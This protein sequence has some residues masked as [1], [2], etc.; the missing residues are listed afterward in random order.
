MKQ[1]WNDIKDGLRKQ[2]PSHSFKM[3]IDPLSFVAEEG[4]AMVLSAPNFFSRKRVEDYYAGAIEEELKKSGEG[5]TRLKVVLS[6]KKRETPGKERPAISNQLILPMMHMQPQNGRRLRREF[7]FDSFVVGG[8]NDFAYSAALSYASGKA[9][10]Q[11]SLFLL[12]NTGMGK[13]HLSQAVGHH[14]LSQSKGDRVY[15]ITAEDFTNEMVQAFKHNCI[16][17][18]KQKYRDGCDV[19]LLE[20]IHFLTG[21]DRTQA[22]LALTLDYL[23]DSRKR[24]I[25]SSCLPPN[26]IPKLSD[27]LRSRISSGLISPI[28]APDFRTR[29]RIVDRKAKEKGIELS[30]EV[31][32]YLASEL[33]EDVRQLESGLIGVAAKSSLMGAEIDIPLAESVV[34]TICVKRK[35]VTIDAI[36]K[37]VCKEYAVTEKDLVS[38]SRKQKVVRPRQVAMY[39]ARR[40][41]DSPLQTIGKSFNRYHATALH[42]I[43]AVE[44]EL[45]KNGAFQ[46]QVELLQK[47][48]EL[49]NF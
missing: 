8:N 36:K 34:R 45:G 43:G 2:I 47:K 42:A 15:Y 12:S 5:P 37:L 22:E 17:K 41:T 27:Q 48:I 13:S 24:V 40:F 4:N 30:R 35:K 25:F 18:F 1:V 26:E 46:K 11:Y 14:I 10:S 32:E 20:D 21:K 49:G 29:V 7:T 6:D 39:L 44:K 19:L 28:E 3:W 23:I 31:Q 33:T 16:D 38:R 9:P